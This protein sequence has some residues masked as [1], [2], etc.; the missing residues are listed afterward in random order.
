MAASPVL[1]QFART[2][3]LNVAFE[4]SGPP[5]GRTVLLLH[6]WPDDVR[7]WDR[8]LP[9]L[10]QAGWRT[11]CP[12]L[13]GFGPTRFL[14]A[15]TLRSGQLTALGMDVLELA[16]ALGL[17]RFAVVG[18]DWGARAAFVAGIV[19]PQRLSHCISLSVGY[20]TNDPGQEISLTQARNYWYHWY[21]ALP[22]G[23][24][25]VREDRLALARLL[26][27]TWAPTWSFSDAE[28]AAT[29][30]A[31]NNPDWADIVLHSYRHRWGLAAGDPRYD[32]I[33]KQMQP[34]PIFQV[35][36]LVIHGQ[37][38]GANEPATSRGRERMFG[39][40]YRR[41]ELPGVGHFPQREAPEIVASEIVEFLSAK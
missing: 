8:L 1:T 13:R 24:R 29:A 11:L 20:G 36:A 19:A 6:G 2:S 40:G 17:E 35:P 14:A 39:A 23:E 7:A 34:L 5:D 27:T 25:M 41:V 16:D 37:V 18:N 32:A 15:E 31:F 10:H 4:E 12:Y 38:D 30:Q 21:M 26:W 28:F 22:R 9:A 33:E 3:L